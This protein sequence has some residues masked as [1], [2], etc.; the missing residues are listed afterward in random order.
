M[1][2]LYEGGASILISDPSARQ[3]ETYVAEINN[4][5][6]VLG[7]YKNA[8][9]QTVDFIYSNGVYTDIGG[10]ALNIAQPGFSDTGQNVFLVN[11]A[12]LTF[13]PDNAPT[14]AGAVTGQTI[15]DG[16]TDSPFSGVTIG[17]SRQPCAN[18]HLDRD[19]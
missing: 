4:A 8:Q 11:G 12:L 10:P 5:G 15:V 18:A 13:A 2:Y 14:I 1:P 19:P 17:K 6:Q 7:Y 16:Q 3:G 9:D